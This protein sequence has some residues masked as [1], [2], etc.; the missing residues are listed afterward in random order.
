MEDMGLDSA[1]G[2]ECTGHMG[3]GTLVG[4]YPEVEFGEE[5]DEVGE[6]DGGRGREGLDPHRRADFDWVLF[7]ERVGILQV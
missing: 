2:R 7:E 6:G 3:L 4:Q 5:A 1:A